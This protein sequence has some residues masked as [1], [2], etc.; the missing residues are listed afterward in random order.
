M[1]MPRVNDIV[2]HGFLRYVSAKGSK[3][4]LVHAIKKFHLSLYYPVIN[5]N[6]RAFSSSKVRC[7]GNRLSDH[8][9]HS[10]P[11]PKTNRSAN[12][13]F[14]IRINNVAVSFN[15]N[16]QNTLYLIKGIS[17]FKAVSNG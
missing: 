7:G 17:R 15:S 6:N 10:I 11:R 3:A 13:N 14:L 5:S 2:D 16:R 12:Y 9:I 4:I 1:S 8:I